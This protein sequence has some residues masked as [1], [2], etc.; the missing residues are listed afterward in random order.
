MQTNLKSLIGKLNAPTRH[1]LESAA[2]QAL[3]RTHH[4]VDIEHVLLALLDTSDSDFLA[5][6]KAYGLEPANITRELQTSLAQFKTGNTRNPVLSQNIPR[7]LEAAWLM[8][9]VDS[10]AESLRSGFLLLALLADAG[11]SR[12]FNGSSDS[13]RKLPL[14]ELRIQLPTIL[15]LS[16]ETNDVL[17]S[18]VVR[19]LRRL[20]CP[21]K[22]Q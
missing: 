20:V 19:A 4:E 11:L 16:R 2:N 6:A 21:A 14:E 10:G 17:I 15:R 5:I 7:W 9:S 18:P 8:A 13:L 12:V 3:S 1:A 22:N